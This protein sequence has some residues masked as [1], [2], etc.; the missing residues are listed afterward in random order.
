MNTAPAT[1]PRVADPKNTPR[2]AARGNAV[3]VGAYQI[4]A[5][6]AAHNE[7]LVSSEEEAEDVDD[8]PLEVLLAS[9]VAAEEYSPIGNHA[10]A[11]AGLER[12]C[13]LGGEYIGGEGERERGA[14]GE[15]ISQSSVPQW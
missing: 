15:S 14:G 7:I 11:G 10:Q 12:P 6:S 8:V 5:A 13:L 2:K 3:V 1:K 4:G 9:P